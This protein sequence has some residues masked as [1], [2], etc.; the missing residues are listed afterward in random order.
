[1]KDRKNELLKEL[2]AGLKEDSGI[3]EISMFTAEELETPMDILRSEITG[4]GPGLISVLGEFFFLPIEDDDHFFFSTVITLSGTVPPEA[5]P[6][7]ASAV[8][9]LNYYVPVGCYALGDD[10]KNLIFRLTALIN[11]S[12]DIKKQS[13]E[14]RK[15]VNIALGAGEKYFGY[16]LMV[17]NNEISVDDMMKMLGGGTL[18]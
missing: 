15:A 10:D 13:G 12:D 16:L 8:A 4:F 2:E 6:D 1:M 5:A 3:G 11:I 7:V 14:I 18:P 9:R 17:I